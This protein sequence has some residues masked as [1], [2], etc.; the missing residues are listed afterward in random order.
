MKRY[1]TKQQLK[2]L[3]QELQYHQKSGLISEA[4]RLDILSVY[5]PQ[6]QLS[7][8][9]IILTIGALLV[10]LGILS[11]I[12]S[13]WAELGKLT[14]F[15][16]I[17]TIFLGPYDPRDLLRGDHVILKY[18]ISEI[19]VSMLPSELR[20]TE[21]DSFE[22][23]YVLLKKNG[24]HYDFNNVKLYKPD[25]GYY[26]K[27]KLQ[28]FSKNQRDQ[29]VAHID[30]SLDKFFVPENTGMELEDKS[31]RGELTARVKIL[32]GYAYLINVE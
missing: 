10:G 28:Y 16:M 14:K 22:E 19:P 23:V 13:N 18:Q 6:Q 7:F 8:V 15:S 26:L 11:F 27:G 17:L 12:A 20:E 24:N 5:E 25:T 32:N 3:D 9:R 31:H 29:E 30:Y 21:R 2:F 1:L 4:Q